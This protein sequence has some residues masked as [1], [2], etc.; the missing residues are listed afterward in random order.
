MTMGKQRCESC[1]SKRQAG[2]QAFSYPV[3]T[4]NQKIQARQRK[5]SFPGH[6]QSTI[7]EFVRIDL[8]LYFP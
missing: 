5:E 4:V 7:A 6:T 1:L 2:I 8:I 3:G